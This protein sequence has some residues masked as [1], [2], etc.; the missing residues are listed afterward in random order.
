VQEKHCFS[1]YQEPPH[2]VYVHSC[3]WFVTS[4]S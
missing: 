4:G 3:Y 2:A 1:L